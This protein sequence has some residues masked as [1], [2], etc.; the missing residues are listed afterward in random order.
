MVGHTKG[1]WEADCCDITEAQV[2]EYERDGVFDKNPKDVG[3]RFWSIR[4]ASRV[5]HCHVHPLDES[6]EAIA[7]RDANARLISAAPELLEACEE[8]L[9]LFDGVTALDDHGSNK[10]GQVE[11][12]MRA[13]IAKAKGETA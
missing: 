2:R 12:L 13:A 11:N 1:P 10:L 6:V 9:T 7:E 3:I 5:S 4:A 8:A